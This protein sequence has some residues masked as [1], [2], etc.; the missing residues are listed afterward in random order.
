MAL[1]KTNLGR[2]TVW[3][4]A[5]YPARPYW[6]VGPDS[7]IFIEE[8][9]DFPMLA[10]GTP[11]AYTTTL[12]NA[13][14]VAL[15]DGNLGGAAVFTSAGAENDGAQIQALG[16]AFLP[17]STNQ[18][19]FGA[20]LQVSNATQCDFLAGLC[21]T[22]TTTLG[23]MTDGIYF[24]KVDETTTCNFVVETGSA[25]TETAA[26]V[27]VAATDYIFE[28]WW[29]GSALNFY[30]DG[31]LTGTPAITY[32]PT[33]EYLT[34]TLAFLTGSADARTMTVSWMRAGQVQV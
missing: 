15:V 31:V 10:A 33:A 19:Y 5:T 6:M 25:E 2:A 27:M 29:N 18:I 9:V 21:I 23:G 32:I 3:Y 8:F 1:T 7:N 26:Q 11:A 17:T 22:D 24:R 16:E 4:D 28:F 20:K 30:V 13:S 34:P 12:V 14:S